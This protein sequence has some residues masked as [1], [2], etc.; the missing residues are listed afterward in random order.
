[1][2]QVERFVQ[3][4]NNESLTGEQKRELVKQKIKELG[5]FTFTNMPDRMLNLAIEIA[6]AQF[7]D[8]LEQRKDEK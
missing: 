6:V 2:E 7:Y 3:M 5:D 4:V 1:M 8:Y